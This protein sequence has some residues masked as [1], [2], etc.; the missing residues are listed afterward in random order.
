MHG[1]V[2][3]VCTA[4]VVVECLDLDDQPPPG[5]SKTSAGHAAMDLSGTRYVPHNLIDQLVSQL[6][7]SAE[8]AGREGRGEE[9]EDCR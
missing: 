3:N 4:Q 1:A 8:R 2:A 5:S 7:G 9:V 6:I